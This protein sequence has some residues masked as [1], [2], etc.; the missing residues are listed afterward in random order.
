MSLSRFFSNLASAYD[1]E[2]NDLVSDSEGKNVLAKRLADKRSQVGFLVHMMEENPEMLAAAFHQGFTYPSPAFMENLVTLEPAA[3]P[4]WSKVASA[5]TLTPWA[6]AL[7]ATVLKEPTGAQ[8]MTVAAALE[9]L[10]N[11]ADDRVVVLGAEDDEDGEHDPD[12]AEFQEA[13]DLEEAGGEWLVE[14]GFDPKP[15]RS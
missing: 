12:E 6:Q 3:F 11:R 14:Q 7:A 15:A 1:A 10:Y 9:Y 8:F 5:I 4:A 13:K 2:I